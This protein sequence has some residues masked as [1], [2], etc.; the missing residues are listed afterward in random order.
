M[1]RGQWEEENREEEEE[2]VSRQE[3]TAGE[4]VYRQGS[5]E[6]ELHTHASHTH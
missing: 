4:Q 6:E 3:G 2:E 5:M 1:E